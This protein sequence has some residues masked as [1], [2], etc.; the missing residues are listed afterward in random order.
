MNRTQQNINYARLQKKPEIAPI[1]QELSKPVH[2]DILREE[3]LKKL[4]P[5]PKITVSQEPEHKTPVI[6]LVHFAVLDEFVH[7]YEANKAGFS[8]AQQKPLN[9]L[10][11]ARNGTLGGCNCNRAKRKAIAEDYFRKFW[12]N[13]KKTDLLP[14]LLNIIKSKKV[15]FGDFLSFP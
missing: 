12:F 5:T 4:N 1:K 10:I 13:N 9:T 2:I 11:E 15:V 6:E 8:E 7:W 3:L 14:T